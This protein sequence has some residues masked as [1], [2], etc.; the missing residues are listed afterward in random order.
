M[1]N[2]GWGKRN[3]FKNMVEIL[4]V[5]ETQKRAKGGADSNSNVEYMLL[6]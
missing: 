1:P 4:T 5:V 3:V 2:N 6:V